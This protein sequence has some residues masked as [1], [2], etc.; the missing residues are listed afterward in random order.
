M[1]THTLDSCLVLVLRWWTTINLDRGGKGRSWSGFKL[2]GLLL[3]SQTF[4]PP[5]RKSD[6]TTKSDEIQSCATSKRCQTVHTRPFEAFS[7]GRS[8]TRQGRERKWINVFLLLCRRS[9]LLFFLFL[10][11]H[12]FFLAS[13]ISLSMIPLIL[14]WI[15]VCFS[16]FLL[17]CCFS[18]IMRIPHVFLCFRVRN[19]VRRFLRSESN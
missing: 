3:S 7:A 6:K 12:C 1:S 13:F 2:A 9:R 14:P 8:V 18:D 15:D 16:F 11:C 4:W 5:K 10:Y 17:C 19:L